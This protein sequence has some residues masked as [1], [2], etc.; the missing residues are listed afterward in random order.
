MFQFTNKKGGGGKDKICSLIWKNINIAQREN[1]HEKLRKDIIGQPMSHWTRDI[2]GYDFFPI[3][4]STYIT[5]VVIYMIYA[6][7]F[8]ITRRGDVPG[9][10]QN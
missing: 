2:V 10:Q 6:L 3:K 9:I 1:I 7:N 5:G 8:F 4:L